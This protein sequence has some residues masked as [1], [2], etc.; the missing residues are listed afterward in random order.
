[1][2]YF[3]RMAPRLINTHARF[4]VAA[5]QHLHFL[6]ATLPQCTCS[7]ALQPTLL[8]L[9]LS[10]TPFRPIVAVHPQPGTYAGL[11]T[12][13]PRPSSNTLSHNPR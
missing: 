1:M 10:R 3:P 4:A 2:A 8:W 11:M 9:P 5:A 13:H 12:C 6:I 7:D